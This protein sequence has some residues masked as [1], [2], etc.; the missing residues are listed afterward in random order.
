MSLEIFNLGSRQTHIINF[1]FL[2]ISQLIFFIIIFISPSSTQ[3]SKNFL[4]QKKYW[5]G[6]HH[7]PTSINCAC[8]DTYK[9]TECWIYLKIKTINSSSEIHN[10]S[11]ISCPSLKKECLLRNSVFY[12]R[13]VSGFL[14]IVVQLSLLLLYSFVN[15]EGARGLLHLN[16]VLS[17]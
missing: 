14:V 3:W 8:G 11:R 7:T 6:I 2:Y 10:Q 12:V 13:S 1:F 17:N 9:L 5:M 15:L 4:R 16:V